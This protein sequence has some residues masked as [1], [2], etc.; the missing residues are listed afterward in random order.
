MKVYTFG[1]SAR[2]LEEFQ[3]ALN[4]VQIDTLVDLRRKP[5]SQYYPHF[6]KNNLEEIFKDKYIFGGNFLGGSPVFHNDLLEYIQ[7][8]GENKNNSN[9][10]LFELIDTNLKDKIFSQDQQF[11]N[12]QKRKF[13]I[14]SN[15]LHE[16]IPEESQDKAVYFLKKLFDKFFDKKICFFCSEKDPTHCHRY[17]LLEKKWLQMFP[18][19]EVI[20]L[21]DVIDDK[22]NKKNNKQISLFT[23]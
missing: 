6:N 23:F 11:S 20:H 10:R 1:H 14:T 19:V 18:G 13:W 15:F 2:S 12:N 7:N 17:H 3:L 5:Q 16:Y 21:E 9:N 22:K 8:R 4:L